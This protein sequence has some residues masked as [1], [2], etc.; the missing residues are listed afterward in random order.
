MHYIKLFFLIGCFSLI[1]FGCKKD[2]A[3]NDCEGLKNALV[4]DAKEDVKAIINSFINKLPSQA[5]TEQNINVLASSILNQCSISTQVFCF[6]CV[7]TLP[8]ITE[9]QLTVTSSQPNIS[10]IIDISYTPENKM[11]C[12]F[13]HD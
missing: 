2:D 5:Y 6:D 3:T 1:A 8:S 11:K 10:K 7:A 12:V 4:I 13:V 9:I